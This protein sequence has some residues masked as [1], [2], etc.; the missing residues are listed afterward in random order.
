MKLYVGTYAK[1][2]AGSLKGAWLDLA[3]YADADAFAAACRRLHK[4]ER[5][6]ELMFQDC[7]TSEDWEQGLYSESSIPREWWALKAEHDAA[8]KKA[9]KSAK[10][11]PL[12]EEWWA[13]TVKC[14][15]YSD[16]PKDKEWHRKQYACFVQLENGG[17]VALD[18]PDIETRF[19]F[20]ENDRGDPNAPDSMKNALD[21]CRYAESKEGF[22]SH[23]LAHIDQW[24]V[25]MFDRAERH[26]QRVFATTAWWRQTEKVGDGYKPVAMSIASEDNWKSPDPRS[27]EFPL[28]E[29]DKAAIVEA[30]KEIRAKFVKRLEAW[31][32]RFGASH[33]HTW[34]YW[35]EA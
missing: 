19:C 17:I 15:A 31:W 27:P 16:N 1:Y 23:N 5:D 11:D 28:T 22:M 14:G 29:K 4:D 2:A 34:T 32:K 21:A 30:Y 13:D 20:G 12:F 24:G 9:P 10:P 6:P 3:N 25:G 7:E 18:K 26:G 8:K 35:T 33:I